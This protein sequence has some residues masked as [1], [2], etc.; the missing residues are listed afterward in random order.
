VAQRAM[1]KRFIGEAV[2]QSGQKLPERGVHQLTESNR[3]E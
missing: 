2:V 1:Q 3:R